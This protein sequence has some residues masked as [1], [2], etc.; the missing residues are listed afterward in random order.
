M[1]DHEATSTTSAVET[2]KRYA[3]GITA[4]VGALLTSGAVVL[5]DNVAPWVALGMAALTAIATTAIPNAAKPGDVPND[6]SPAGYP[7]AAKTEPG[8]AL[9]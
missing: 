2:V 4:T 1:G 7:N 5:P 8:D 3:K 9:L 6:H